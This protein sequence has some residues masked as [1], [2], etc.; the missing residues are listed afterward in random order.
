MAAL[1]VVARITTLIATTELHGERGCVMS[2]ACYVEL[3]YP[4]DGGCGKK[5]DDLN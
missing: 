5:A 2:K 1:P 3:E 4:Q